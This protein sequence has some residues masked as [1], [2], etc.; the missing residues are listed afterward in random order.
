MFVTSYFLIGPYLC[1][2]TTQGKYDRDGVRRS[3]PH[4]DGFGSLTYMNYGL[5]N[6]LTVGLIPTFGYNTSR[7]MAVH[8]N[9]API[10]LTVSGQ[11]C[12]SSNQK[13]RWATPAECGETSEV[14]RKSACLRPRV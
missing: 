3:A 6:R 4:A 8:E 9:C 2:V 5:R 14:V 1:D 12:S 7:Q 13:P 10:G 11:N